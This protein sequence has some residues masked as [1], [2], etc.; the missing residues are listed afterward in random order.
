MDTKEHKLHLEHNTWTVPSKLSRYSSQNLHM[1]LSNCVSSYVSSLHVKLHCMFVGHE[2]HIIIRKPGQCQY[3]IDYSWVKVEEN[4]SVCQWTIPTVDE[5]H[6]LTGL[7]AMRIKVWIGSVHLRLLKLGREFEDSVEK[8]F[9]PAKEGRFLRLA[10]HVEHTKYGDDEY[11][12]GSQNG[13]RHVPRPLS[14]VQFTY[15]YN[16]WLWWRWR[17]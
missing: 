16:Q 10:G 11:R 1:K 7:A 2:V 14:L 8:L 5:L 6:R 4:R 15:D 17:Q 13:H 12:N 3:Y 9:V